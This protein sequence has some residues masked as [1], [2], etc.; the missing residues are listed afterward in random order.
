[1]AIEKILKFTWNEFIYGGHLLSLGGVAI[2]LFSG[3]LLNI[4]ITW[5][6]LF[7]VYLIIY[8]VYLY[9]RFKE[10]HIDYLT[11]P[12]RT[13]H[14][15]IYFS[16]I[17]KIFYVIIFI[18]IGSLIYFSNVW[19][20]IFGLSLLLLGWLYTIVFKKIT[21]KIIIFKNLSVS[22]TFSLLVFFPLI[23]YSCPL[24]ISILSIAFLIVTFVYFKAFTMQVFLDVKDV[25]SDEK[26]GLLT[27]P[28]IF[29]KEKTL[30]ILGIISLLSTAPIPIIFS[31]YFNIFPISTLMLL[32]TIPFNFFCFSQAKN[33]NYH[34][35]TLE[36]SEFILWPILILIGEIII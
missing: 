6:C 25:E 30:N 26:Q 21:K 28:V 35:Y 19:A 29:G 10:V 8:I 32:L 33:Q 14:L 31:L 27:F 17:P 12:Q 1:M 7:V 16:K 36:S 18:I 22:A 3:I 15:K 4:K 11:N 9:N 13:K 23:Y 20:L 5:D 34:S 24:T 2:V